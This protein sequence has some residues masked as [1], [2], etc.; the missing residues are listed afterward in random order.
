MQPLDDGTEQRF[1]G[2]E[3]MVQRLPRQSGR[4]RR[5]LDRGAPEPMPAEHGHGGIE[6]AVARLH[7]SNLTKADK[8]SNNGFVSENSVGRPGTS[9]SRQFGDR[10]TRLSRPGRHPTEASS[11]SR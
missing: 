3:M 9:T 2:L 10:A 1:L 4:L 11:G 7:L 5:L 8:M 6:D